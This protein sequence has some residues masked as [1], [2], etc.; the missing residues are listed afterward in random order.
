MFFRKK[1]NQFTC[2]IIDHGKI[3]ESRLTRKGEF[4]EDAMAGKSYAIVEPPVWFKIGKKD[5]QR[6][7]VD[8]QKGCTVRLARDAQDF[9]KVKT[10]P[11]LL[12]TVIG[13]R[14]VKD[15][16]DIRPKLISLV[17]CLIAGIGVGFFFGLIM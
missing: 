17:I 8:E 10:N 9:L 14:L 12:G 1:K 6:F 15:A 3:I 5:E 13:S 16:F 11:D 2:M 7:I 4:L